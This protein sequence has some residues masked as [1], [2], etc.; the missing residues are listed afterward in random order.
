M[1]LEDSLGSD[2]NFDRFVF[3]ESIVDSD[4][5]V[6]EDGKVAIVVPN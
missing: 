1:S 3:L 5:L 4:D 2:W 6:I